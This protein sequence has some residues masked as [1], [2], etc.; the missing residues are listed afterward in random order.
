MDSSAS[1]IAQTRAL[2]G[3]IGNAAQAAEKYLSTVSLRSSAQEQLID[4]ELRISVYTIEAACAQLCALVA[5]PSDTLVNVC[6]F[7]F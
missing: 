7:N 2:L 4:P 1:H 3:L 5:R 6:L